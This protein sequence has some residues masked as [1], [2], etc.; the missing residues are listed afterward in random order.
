MN[1]LFKR[2]IMCL[3]CRYTYYIRLNYFFFTN[4]MRIYSDNLIECVLSIKLKHIA[5]AD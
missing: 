2:K 4:L 5:L 3:I 1:I